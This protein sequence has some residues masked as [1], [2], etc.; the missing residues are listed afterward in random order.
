MFT[1]Q[2]PDHWPQVLIDAYVLGVF[3]GWDEPEIRQQGSTMLLQ[4]TQGHF[5]YVV[6]HKN[7]DFAARMLIQGVRSMSQPASVAHDAA[8]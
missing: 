6:M 1:R 5:S 4:A 8:G 2:C 7:F 3:D